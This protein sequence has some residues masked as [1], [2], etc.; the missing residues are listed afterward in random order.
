MKAAKQAALFEPD[1]HWELCRFVPA[2]PPRRMCESHMPAEPWDEP[3][4][5]HSM[6]IAPGAG[7]RVENL[8]KNAISSPARLSL[9]SDMLRT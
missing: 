7:P 6:T 3:L 8:K 4:M 9:E 2:V 5:F 1:G